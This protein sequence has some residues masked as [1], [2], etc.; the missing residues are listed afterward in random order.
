MT[1]R[2]Y[3]RLLERARRQLEQE[4]VARQARRRPPALPKGGPHRR[5]PASVLTARYVDVKLGDPLG[6]AA[7]LVQAP[8]FGLFVGLAFDGR[9][10]SLPLQFTLSMIA[11]WFGV[12][13]ACREVVKERA[14]F[15]R[16]RRIGV[17]VSAYLASK[18]VVLTCLSTVQCLLLLVVVSRHVRFEASLPAVFLVLALTAFSGVTLG[19]L[20]SS[21]VASQNSLI[22]LVPVVLIPQLV[23]S[24]LLIPRPPASVERIEHALIADWS[25]GLLR[26][27]AASEADWPGIVGGAGALLGLSLACTALAWACLALRSE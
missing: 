14:I 13:D 11:V 23:F 2:R 21:A 17:P 24:D 3:E 19:L 12:F 15:L 5:G 8:L 20:I 1:D 10:E 22:A 9:A 27:L 16:E 18:L 25:L 26:D 7:T 4:K 6:T